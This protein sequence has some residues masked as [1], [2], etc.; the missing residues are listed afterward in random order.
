MKRWEK[1]GKQNEVMKKEKEGQYN[2]EMER[3]QG[4]KWKQGE[5]REFLVFKV[6]FLMYGGHSSYR[7]QQGCSDEP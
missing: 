1:Q 2:E 5:K 3:K 7:L 4:K 6:F